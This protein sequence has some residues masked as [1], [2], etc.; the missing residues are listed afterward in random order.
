M[1]PI[2]FKGQEI[3]LRRPPGMTEEE[4]GPLPIVRLGETCVSCWK[5]DWRERLKALFTGVVWVGVL[6]GR[7]QPP[8]YAA[9]DRPF[10][11]NEPAAGECCSENAS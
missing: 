7:T 4:C 8:I 3:E 5:M 10:R 2:S 1:K 11:I 9:V 6:S